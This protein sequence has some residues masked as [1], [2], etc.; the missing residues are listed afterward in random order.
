MSIADV[1][2]QDRRFGTFLI[3]RKVLESNPEEVMQVFPKCVVLRAELDWANDAIVYTAWSPL[4]NPVEP[5]M[6]PP[7]YQIRITDTM[8]AFGKRKVGSV[9]LVLLGGYG[10]EAAVAVK[11]SPILTWEKLEI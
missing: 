8:D 9:R 11:R 1:F 10:R 4:F 5:N 7:V 3:S 2:Q 6:T